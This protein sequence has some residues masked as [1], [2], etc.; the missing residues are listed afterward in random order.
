VP[1]ALPA[2]LSLSRFDLQK[3]IEKRKKKRQ[4][5][6]ERV[7]RK[8]EEDYVKTTWKSHS[9]RNGVAFLLSFR[10]ALYQRSLS[11]GE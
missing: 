11:S 3:K 4:R 1:C 7:A 2:D 6:R 5:E 9:S 8:M 10:P